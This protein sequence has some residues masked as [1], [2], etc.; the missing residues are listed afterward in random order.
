[1]DAAT[2]DLRDSISN[3]KLVFYHLPSEKGIP[4]NGLTIG[5]PADWLSDYQLRH[6]TVAEDDN[7]KARPI[8]V[9][10]IMGP[11]KFLRL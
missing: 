4:I 1:M 10:R 3:K 5:K 9:Y 7:N 6:N 8:I 11:M 2:F